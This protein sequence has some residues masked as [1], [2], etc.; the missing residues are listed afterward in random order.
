MKMSSKG[1]RRLED[2]LVVGR[3]IS[4]SVN[5]EPRYVVFHSTLPRNSKAE[6]A[7][8]EFLELQ[9]LL[10]HEA[11]FYPSA[12]VKNVKV[13]SELNLLLVVYR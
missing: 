1:K 2:A 8:T 4:A 10:T 6:I 5:S 13:L 7:C 9:L 11:H 3:E 12:N